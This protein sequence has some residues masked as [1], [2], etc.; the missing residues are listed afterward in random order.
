V[1]DLT[2]TP[3]KFRPTV[4]T[5][6]SRDAPVAFVPTAIEQLFLERLNDARAN[7]AAYGASIGLDLGGVGPAQPLAFNV[8][9]IAAARLHSEDMAAR[10]YFAHV[11]PEGLAPI[12]RVMAA[13]LRRFK[14][15]GESISFGTGFSSFSFTPTGGFVTTFIPYGPTDSLRDLIIDSGIPSLGHRRHLLAIDQAF[16]SDKSVG[17]GEADNGSRASFYTIDT[18]GFD[19]KKGKTEDSFITGCAFRDT[20]RNGVYD[21][22]EGLGGVSLK[23]TQGG[24]GAGSEVTWGS[25]G[26]SHEVKPG[27]YKV[28]ASGGGLP[29]TLTRTVRVSKQNVRVNFVV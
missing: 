19:V 16:Q 24:K 6:E 5:L 3:P 10:G 8:I 15:P 23:F 1:S 2:R 11:T 28:T 12:D 9:L 21:I 29:G 25:G 27:V 14:G 26:Y 13:G 4:E 20:N 17:I 7:P 18:V 22:G